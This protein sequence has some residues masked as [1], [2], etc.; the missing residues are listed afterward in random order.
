[1]RRGEWWLVVALFAG[2]FA[3]VVGTAGDYGATYDEPH[4]ASAGSK[5]ATWWVLAARSPA[6]AFQRSAIE[7]A[8]RPNHEH[9]PLQKVASG[10]SYRWLPGL[11]PGLTAMRLPSAFWFA[12][13]AVGLFLFARGI[14]S[15]GGA[16][17]AALAFI[18][19]PHLFAH[20]HFVALDMPIT[21]WFFFT[22][23][24][25][26]VALTRDSWPWTAL[27]GIAFG[28]AL[29]SKINALFLPLLLL[30]WA[31]IWHRR[32]W[33]KAAAAV[34]IGAAVFFVGWPWLWIAPV[35]HLKAYL[36]FHFR[37]AAYNVWYLGKLHQY[38]PWHYPFV[39]T[40]VSTPALVLLMS[41][42]GLIICRPR[43]GNPR[44][45]L[46]V[47]GFLISLAPSALPT[48]PKYNGVRLFLLAFPFLAALAGAGFARL[49]SRL[50][51]AGP[52]SRPTNTGLARLVALLVGASLLTPSVRAL[53]R[54]HP[55]QLAYYNAFV[56]GAAGA[57]ES[58]FETIYWGQ[59]LS[60]GVDFVNRI[61]KASPFLLVIPKG[62]I[63]LFHLQ[64]VRPDAQFTADESQAPSVDYVMFQCMQSDFTDLCWE[65]YRNA[66]PAFSV[67]LEGTPLLV[68]YDRDAAAAAAARL[69]ARPAPA[70][71]ATSPAASSETNRPTRKLAGS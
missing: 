13:A 14:W 49:E 47:L 57:A 11:L 31:L 45:A 32:S 46:L 66:E 21:A 8:W 15:L 4:Y 25:A 7:A 63:Y 24:L 35:A 55:Y 36:A 54:T 34:A 23:A 42:A 6:L 67:Q 43:R 56:G 9:P 18:T 29:L 65:L 3:L 22:A 5:Y 70:A 16:L 44:E 30:P 48:S 17:F 38:A 2:S 61:E 41:L 68:A 64:Q 60:Q 27:A 59:V 53:A 28:L 37:H 20:A 58:G 52:L 51:R 50:F 33:P 40:A 62:V 12:L 19:M 71:P 1:M 26:A 69:S 10:F 39:M